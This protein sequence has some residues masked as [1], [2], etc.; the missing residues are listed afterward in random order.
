MELRRTKNVATYIVFPIV[1]ADGDLVTG[2]TGLDSEIDAWAN[3]SAPDGF[4]DCS[5]EATEIGSSG[6]Y[7]LSLTQAEMNSDYIVVQVKTSTSGAKTQVIL[8][9]TTNQQADVAAISGDSA[10]AD[11]LE[12][13]CD[14]T[15]PQPVNV[16]QIAANAITAAAIATDAIDADA[17]AADA[18][19]E[20]ADAL[21][22]RDMSAVTGEAARSPLNALRALR[23]KVA[24]SGSTLTVS[25]EDDATAAWTATVATDGAAEPITSVDP[26]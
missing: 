20:V 6:M 9:N 15:T 17:L 11:N 3:G 7:Y 26:A 24:I 19:T 23:N 14:G 2:A 18:A 5:N 12:S 10:A 13:Y 4:T 8:I 25:K 1:D 16:T 22:K 21:L